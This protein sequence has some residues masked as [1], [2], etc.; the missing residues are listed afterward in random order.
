MSM[1][2]RRTKQFVIFSGPLQMVEEFQQDW[3]QHSLDISEM[4]TNA[5][6]I[7][8]TCKLKIRATLENT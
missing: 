3:L 8:T 5:T 1:Q 7:S 2:P 4:F 6:V